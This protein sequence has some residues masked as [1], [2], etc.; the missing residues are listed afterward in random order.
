M[1]DDKPKKRRKPAPGVFGRPPHYNVEAEEAVLG[2]CMIDPSGMDDIPFLSADDFYRHNHQT[3]FAVMQDLH[4]QGIPL[5][6][7]VVHDQLERQGLLGEEGSNPRDASVTMYTTLS[8][9]M[10]RVPTAIHLV[11]Y[12]RIVEQC[13][14]LR[15]LLY[16]AEKIAARTYESLDIDAIVSASEHDLHTA[17]HRRGGSGTLTAG[18]AGDN[19]LMAL[20]ETHQGARKVGLP[21]SLKAMT[22]LIRTWRYGRQ[23]ILAARTSEGKTSLAVH[24]ALTQAAAGYRVVY[25]TYE[26]SAEAIAFRCMGHLEGLDIQQME[27][28]W[29]PMDAEI[30]SQRERV[31]PYRASTQD[32]LE[33]RA[34]SAASKL[35]S[36]PLLLV[37]TSDQDGRLQPPRTLTDL[38]AF[39]RNLVRSQQLDLLVIDYLG[40]MDF[41]TYKDAAHHS[42]NVGE[43]ARV[44]KEMGQQYGY[45]TLLLH[46]LSRETTKDKRPALH[47]L[48]DSGKLEQHAD[49]VLFIYDLHRA[50]EQGARPGDKELIVAKHRQGPI[51]Y[52]NANVL[53]PTG[54]WT[55]RKLRPALA[56]PP[57]RVSKNDSVF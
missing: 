19:A 53:L 43:A 17:A 12:A 20:L 23:T 31:Y 33:R 48:Q 54:R 21:V 8:Q 32:E 5:D 25:I 9:L 27:D 29:N 6:P 15:R 3:I 16:A 2:S 34:A 28:G 11:H 7:L 42:A 40:L 36:L 13:A 10:L 22:S 18:E 44:I 26:M 24:E 37:G 57:A 46:Q 55:S 30:N 56:S 47:H 38:R 51:G 14:V 41:G 52:V 4:G 35:G 45:H 49:V 39:I 50:K 1:T